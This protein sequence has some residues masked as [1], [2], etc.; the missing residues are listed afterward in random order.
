LHE[1]FVS[2]WSLGGACH[3]V[4]PWWAQCGCQE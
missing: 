4:T 3:C 2:C 1:V